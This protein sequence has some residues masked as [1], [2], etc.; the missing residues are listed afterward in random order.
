MFSLLCLV[1]TALRRIFFIAPLV[2]IQP[3]PI[4][5]MGGAVRVSNYVF[6]VL[7]MILRPLLTVA[8]VRILSL[9]WLLEVSILVFSS[10]YSV[11]SPIDGAT[12]CLSRPSICRSTRFCRFS[13]PLFQYLQG[14]RYFGVHRDSSSTANKLL[15]RSRSLLAR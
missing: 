3:S 13:I 2:G 4:P 9:P 6:P 15:H 8:L 14:V 5:S 12:R 10:L 11:C 1:I 7:L